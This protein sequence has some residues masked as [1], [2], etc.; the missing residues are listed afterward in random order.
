MGRAESE[1][2]VSSSSALFSSNPGISLWTSS[3][4]APGHPTRVLSRSKFQN[5]ID[6]SITVG[7]TVVV[8]DAYG[9][10]TRPAVRR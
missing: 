2:Q 4:L 10:P 1:G 3:M 6:L 8:D 5:S 7:F 9:D